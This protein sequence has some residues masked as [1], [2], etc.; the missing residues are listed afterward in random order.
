[1]ISSSRTA[2]KKHKGSRG[3]E[4]SAAYEIVLKPN[5]HLQDGEL[6]ACELSGVQM[7]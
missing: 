3:G 6:E 7:S 4:K 2:N 1:M 5:I